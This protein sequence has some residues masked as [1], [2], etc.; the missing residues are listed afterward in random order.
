MLERSSSRAINMMIVHAIIRQ[1]ILRMILLSS[2]QVHRAEGSNRW[3]FSLW[4]FV[5]KMTCG[6]GG[7]LCWRRTETCPVH[8]P[9]IARLILLCSFGIIEDAWLFWIVG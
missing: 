5:L 7:T 3:R 4:C 9:V 8:L 2:A 6:R 1:S